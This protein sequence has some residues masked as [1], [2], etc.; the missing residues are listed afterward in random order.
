MPRI[1]FIL[2]HRDNAYTCDP[3]YS[4]NHLSS[5]LWNSARFVQEMLRD[6]LGHETCIEHAVDNNAIDRLVSAFRPDIVI[7][8]AYW[9]VP[10]K[11]DVLIKLHPHV[12][13]VIRNHSPVPFA[14]MEGVVM[15]WSLRYMDRQNIILACNDERADRDFRNLISVYKPEWEDELFSRC[16]LLPNY[17]PSDY[18]PRQSFGHRPVVDIGCF[19]AIRPLKNQLIQA[20]AAIEYAN[21]VKKHLRFH[22]NSTRVEGRGD[23]ILKNLRNLFDLVSYELVE[24]DWMPHD[25]F[26]SLIRTMDIGLQVSYSESFNIVSADMVVNGVPVVVSPE[27]RWVNSLFHADPNSSSSIVEAIERAMMAN[28]YLHFLH[29]NVHALH[30]YDEDSMVRWR[31]FIDNQFKS[32]CE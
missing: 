18:D 31:T 26:I 32:V 21:K 12:L 10:E 3:E 16:I 19:G 24:H 11:F 15:D 6:R 17:Y 30:T 2:K 8:E 25:G 7:I 5:G 4:H 9:V 22:I 27:I 23:A 28:H 29:P 1:Q 13:W 20:V 14:S